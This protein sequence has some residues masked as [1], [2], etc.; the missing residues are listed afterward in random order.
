VKKPSTESNDSIQAQVE[1]LTAEAKQLNLL[2]K[3][4]QALEIYRKA[5]LLM[6]GAP[7]LQHRTAE[8][9]RR[10]KQSDIAAQHYRRAAAAFIG[11]GFP[12]RAL[13]PYRNAWAILVVALPENA[14]A[15]ITLTL[16]LADLQRQLGAPDEATTSIARA[17]DALRAAGCNEQVP[18][19]AVLEA[20]APLAPEVPPEASTAGSDP[21]AAPK[22]GVKPSPKPVA[23][24]FL[25][26]FRGIMKP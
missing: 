7:W 24:G 5:S 26:G 17:N 11:A 16:N 3:E 9:A 23:L 14:S 13:A 8:L 2:G 4:A 19:P 10:L 1:Q 12:K 20:G 22:S 6:P 18:A 21:P 25:A 15:F